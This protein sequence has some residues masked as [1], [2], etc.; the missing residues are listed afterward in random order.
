VTNT[1]TFFLRK[2][3]AKEEEEEEE[4]KPCHLNCSIHIGKHLKVNDRKEKKY[5]YD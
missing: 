4:R 5:D 3:R 2:V 1:Y